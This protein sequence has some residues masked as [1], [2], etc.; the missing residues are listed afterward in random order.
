MIKAWLASLSRLGACALLL[1]SAFPL[2]AQFYTTGSDPAR[3][4][5]NRIDLP[6]FR[7]IYPRGLDSLAFQ[8]AFQLETQARLS[9][10]GLQAGFGADRSGRSFGSRGSI[11][12]ILH[13]YSS[14]QNGMVIWAPRRAELYTIPLAEGTALEWSR[15]LALHEGRH[16]AQMQKAGEGFFKG[17]HFVLGEQSEGLSAGLLDFFSPGLLEGDAVWA[18]TR[19]SGAGRGRQAEFLM[20]YKALFLDSVKYSLDKYRF[21]SYKN[22]VPNEYALGYLQ[23]SAAPGAGNAAGI[24]EG[25]ARHPFRYRQAYRASV[26]CAPR[27]LWSNAQQ[28]YTAYWRQQ[29]AAEAPF[30][31]AVLVSPAEERY[32]EYAYPISLNGRIYAVR[33]GLGE[34]SRLVCLENG[35]ARRLCLTGSINGPLSGSGSVLYWTETVSSGRW[36]HES[37]SILVS[38]DIRQGKRHSLSHHTRYFNPS[39][40]PDGRRVALAEYL[41]DGHSRL[42]IYLPE[43]DRFHTVCTF[44]IGVTLKQSAWKDDDTLMATLQYPEGLAL[45]A[46][47]AASGAVTQWVAPQ[48][49]TLRSL[50]IHQGTL[51]FDSDLDGTDNLYALDLDTRALSR[52]S[53]ARFG[54]FQPSV[55][56]D[57]DTLLYLSY[58][59]KGYEVA[60]FPLDELDEARACEA[61]F[62]VPSPTFFDRWLAGRGDTVPAFPASEAP[63][64]EVKPYHRLGHFL[65]FHSWAPF[66]YDKDELSSFSLERYYDAVS[67]GAMVMTQNDLGTA[68]GQLGWSWHN[69]VNEGRLKFT[70]AGMYPVLTASLN[71]STEQPLA[72][73]VTRDTVTYAAL[74][75]PSVSGYVRAY[76]PFTFRSRGWTR[77]LVP[78]LQWSF[79]NRQ[80][81]KESAEAI[82]DH[83][84]LAALQWNAYVNRTACDL[85][86]RWGYGFHLRYLTFPGQQQLFTDLFEAGAQIY[87]PGFYRNHAFRLK[88]NYQHHETGNA[89]LYVGNLLSI[90]GAGDVYAPEE[91]SWSVD[92]AFPVNLDWSLP[93]FLYVKRLELTPFADGLYAQNPSSGSAVGMCTLGLESSLNFHLLRI[94]C[95]LTAGLRSQYNTAQGA[96]FEFLLSLP[97]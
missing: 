82:A 59:T 28:V 10:Q 76:V 15:D 18:E 79:S 74:D 24:F 46:V 51:Y 60:A 36:E 66:Y 90:R 95:N 67:L 80:F 54:A 88:G 81:Q 63:A 21:G 78:S 5:W 44:P 57:G 56:A 42:V 26:G 93:G 8:Y 64:Y 43:I 16:M 47:S 22:F 33:S 96:S 86:P 17:L 38:Y 13:A 41:P 45:C 32:I 30:D 85:F 40:S 1:L 14:Q 2:K 39:A 31:T 53:H 23:L 4:Q 58:S 50:H 20:P 3:L 87:L 70:Y 91:F 37:F 34:S 25:I 97:Y 27:E 55:T 49:R 89:W 69:G 7:L 11:P 6:G 48:Q 9:L 92:Y 73:H 35:S 71:V 72:T 61:D 83:R 77:T 75:E 68:Y 65:K 62:T 12:V 52:I 19:Y 29:A 94:N 84:L